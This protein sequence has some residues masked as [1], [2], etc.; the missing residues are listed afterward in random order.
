MQVDFRGLDRG[1]PKIF[2]DH[3][4]ILGS[5][6]KFTRITMADLMRGYP[7][8]GVVLENMLDSTRR[9]MFPL[10]TNKK[11][12]DNPVANEF[13]NIGKRIVINEHDPDLIPFTSDTNGML[14]EINVLDIHIAE[15]GDTDTSC[16]D[17]PDNELVPDIS[18]RIDQAEN[19]V[20]FEIF[21]ILLLD[22]GPVNSCQRICS[23]NTLGIE[24]P[25]KGT[26]GGDDSVECLGF[27]RLHGRDKRKKIVHDHR[28]NL[29]RGI[30][31]CLLK[32]FPVEDELGHIRVPAEPDVIPK[33]LDHLL[34]TVKGAGRIVPHSQVVPVAF[35]P[36]RKIP[37]FHALFLFLSNK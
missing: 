5:L 8:R 18:N 37:A 21:D 30:Q 22:P 25:I 13:E 29:D 36:L 33:M 15:L 6:V 34:I 26:Q 4:E 24:V 28:V 9:D 20:M 10:L 23:D 12:A 17:G 16:I 2:L 7:G 32:I 11:R 31:S 14:I 19:L 3:S 1:M 35:E 27:V